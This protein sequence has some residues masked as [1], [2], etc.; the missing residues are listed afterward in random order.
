M[1]LFVPMLTELLAAKLVLPA[2]N[3]LELLAPKV[4]ELLKPVLL[5][6]N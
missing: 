2:P 3:M 5:V 4:L 6:P 1:F